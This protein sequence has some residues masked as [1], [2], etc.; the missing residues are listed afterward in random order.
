M[1]FDGVV[2]PATAFLDV[3][4]GL[5]PDLDRVVCFGPEPIRQ[6]LIPQLVREDLQIPFILLN[7]YDL[8]KISAVQ[9][10]SDDFDEEARQMTSSLEELS[11]GSLPL[12]IV[13]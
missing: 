10:T 6:Y 4:A 12:S 3:V 5:D 11:E 9:S 13:H 2:E 1:L 8:S 7:Y